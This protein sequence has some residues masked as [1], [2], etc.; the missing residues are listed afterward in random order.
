ME[1]LKYPKEPVH[2]VHLKPNAI[3]FDETNIF[4]SVLSASDL[5]LGTRTGTGEFNGVRDE[6]EKHKLQHRRITI[7]NGQ[8]TR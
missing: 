4:A 6:I 1:T 3:V 7:Y 8:L 2:I 5:D